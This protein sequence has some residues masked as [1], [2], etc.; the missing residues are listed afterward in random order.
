M[1]LEGFDFI[2]IAY[3]AP[4]LIKEWHMNP[5]TFGTIVSVGFVGVL[6]GNVLLGILGDRIGRKKAIVVS[7]LI[8]GLLTLV[9]TMANSPNVLM[10][11]RL[12]AGIG[13]GG[14]LPLAMVLVDEYAPKKSKSKWDSP[15]FLPA[16]F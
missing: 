8:F 12:L 3:I 2:G 6:I 9:T 13:L 16:Y 15:A 14:T 7:V 10:L 1:L 4:P 5:A 11:L